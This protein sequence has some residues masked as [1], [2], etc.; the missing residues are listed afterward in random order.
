M[1]S[2]A[3][4]G[5]NTNSQLRLPESVLLYINV[6][7]SFFLHLVRTV[8]KIFLKNKKKRC[9][10]CKEAESDETKQKLVTYSCT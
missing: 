1:I 2:R 10:N 6:E 8:S 3:N 4:T 5:I 7:P 9:L